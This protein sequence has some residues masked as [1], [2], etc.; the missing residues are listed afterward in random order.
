MQ[1]W[2]PVPMLLADSDDGTAL[3]ARIDALKDHPALAVW[4]AP[5]EAI[6]S[7]SLKDNAARMAFW[8]LSPEKIAEVERNHDT[9]VRGLERGARVV[10]ERSPGKPIWLNE[11]V[12][13]DQVTLARCV[14]FLDIV[15]FDWY[16]IRNGYTEPMGLVGKNIARFARTAP[17]CGLWYVQQAFSWSKLFPAEAPLLLPTEAETRFMAWEAIL[18]GATGIM[19][20]GSAYADRPHPFFDGLMAVLSEFRDLHQFLF[21][22]QIP[23]VRAEA[24]HRQNE[25]ILGVGVVARRAGDKILITLI[26]QDPHPLSAVLLGV[27]DNIISRLRLVSGPDDP[28]VKTPEGFISEMQGYEVRIYVAD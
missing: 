25:P 27:E 15:G 12:H 17:R 20:W 13:S 10:R 21:A 14:P 8:K 2:V 6:W 24:Y 5:D 1:G 26:N 18:H 28:F 9:M 3:A 7:A 11:A 22:G 19:W 23:N 16:P 4:E